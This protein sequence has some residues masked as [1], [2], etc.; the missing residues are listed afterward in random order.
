MRTL[1]RL[2]LLIGFFTILVL[3]Y[4]SYGVT[5]IT[6]SS[7]TV[8]VGDTVTVNINVSGVATW[9]LNVGYSN[10]QLVSGNT[11]LVRPDN[12]IDNVSSVAGTLVF[13][14]ISTG[15]AT[16][17]VT[18]NSYTAEGEVSNANASKNIT[19][20]TPAPQVTPPPVQTTTEKPINKTEANTT[21][22]SNKSTTISNNAYL[23][24]FRVNVEGISPP[25]SKAIYNYSLNVG[26]DIESIAVTAIAEDPNANVNIS[27]NTGLKQGENIIAVRVTAEDNRTIKT[28]NINVVKSA[29]PVLS[30]AYL[31]NLVVSNSV[32]NQEFVK[33]IFNYTCD[34]A[35]DVDRLDISTFPENENATVRVE[36]N[37]GL[38]LG[39]N[40]V[41]II[42][43]SEDKS[44]ENIY[45][46]TAN[47]EKVGDAELKSNL[48][49]TTNKSNGNVLW[50]IIKENGTTLALYFLIWVEFLQVVYLYEKYVRPEELGKKDKEIKK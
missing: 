10:L 8:N 20:V 33:E 43:T 39:E 48:K 27:G 21:T 35:Y 29:N 32:L 11:T 22:K 28:Y 34:I 44:I 12:G 9:Q 30:N 7:S 41:K 25:F 50:K 19:V 47:K 16:I 23:K 1:R 17:S 6:T 24:E 31:L 15:S 18:G 3:L 4:N 46:I 13:K 2:I 40:I 14:T 45:T 26:D 37:E 42:V 38:K 49:L 36:G 5:S